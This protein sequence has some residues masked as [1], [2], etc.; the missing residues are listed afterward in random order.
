[1]LDP[2]DGSVLRAYEVATGV[3][4]RPAALVLY[5][6]RWD[7]ADLAVYLGQFRRPHTG[8]DDDAKAWGIL[9]SLVTGLSPA[10]INS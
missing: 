1:M 7:I 2:G 3:V 9:Q 5:Q 8:T 6:L 4:P 10:S